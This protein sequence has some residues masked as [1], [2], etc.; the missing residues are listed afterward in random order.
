MIERK[1]NMGIKSNTQRS[2]SLLRVAFVLTVIALIILIVNVNIQI[3]T[4][5]QRAQV[6]E[7]RIERIDREIERMESEY[8]KPITDEM[9]RQ[10]ARDTLGFYMSNEIIYQVS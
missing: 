6:L 4:Y 10:M 9:M 8:K 3:N 5:K 1:L 2:S 7:S